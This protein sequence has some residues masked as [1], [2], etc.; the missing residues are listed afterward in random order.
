MAEPIENE[1]NSVADA[2]IY[3]D[4]NKL[5]TE[6]ILFSLKAIKKNPELSIQDALDSGLSEWIK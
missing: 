5:L 2:L 3:A 6:V 4:E 1:L